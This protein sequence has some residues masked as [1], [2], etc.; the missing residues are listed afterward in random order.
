MVPRYRLGLERLYQD[1]NANMKLF[2]A[3]SSPAQNETCCQSGLSWMSSEVLRTFISRMARFPGIRLLGSY[4]AS[5][6]VGPGETLSRRK[7]QH[8]AVPSFII[9]WA[10]RDVLSVG[11][12]LD[13]IGGSANLHFPNGP[14]S[15]NPSV[16][17]VWCLDISWSQ[18]E[19][20][21]T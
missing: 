5:I 9:P 7:R 14:L 15:W 10:K 21:K 20:L 1:V 12:V 19:C 4:G 6:S 18:R 16:R 13:V 2:P 17:I 3:L 11:V 8:E